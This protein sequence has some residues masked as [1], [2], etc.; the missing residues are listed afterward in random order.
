[1]TLY[2]N[3]RTLIILPLACIAVAFVL[4]LNFTAPNPTGRRYSSVIPSQQAVITGKQDW[5]EAE[6]VLEHDLGIPFNDSADTRQ[7][8]CNV[9]SENGTPPGR[10][11]VCLVPP[12]RISQNYT[13]PDF[14]TKDLIIDSKYVATFSIDAQIED[15]ITAAQETNREVWIFVR[16]NTNFSPATQSRIQATGGD[17]IPYFVV[18]SYSDPLDQLGKFL[19]IVGGTGIALILGWE[20][21]RWLYNPSPDDPH[22][23][24]DALDTIDT[25]DTVDDAT[26]TVDETEAFMRRVERLSR[27][28][29]KKRDDSNKKR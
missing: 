10:C 4:L 6:I 22:E 12:V 2:L 29:I 21:W 7:C 1:M 5:R 28:E 13:L 11:N 24:V 17:I 16:I 9:G 19:L 20:A 23:D 25:I 8:I 15:F 18:D 27:K 26:D 14:V 3:W